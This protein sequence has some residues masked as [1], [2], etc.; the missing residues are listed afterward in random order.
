M[1]AAM[2]IDSLIKGLGGPTAVGHALGLS[3][4]RVHNW[5][6]RDSVP[7]EHHLAVWRLAIERQIDWKPPG[8][9]GLSLVAAPAAEE[10][11]E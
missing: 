9:D 2:K 10:A 4:Q 7:A 3:P 1:M 5:I 11:A 6:V 8:A